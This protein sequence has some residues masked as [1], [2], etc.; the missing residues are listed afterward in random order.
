MTVDYGPAEYRNPVHPD[1]LSQMVKTKPVEMLLPFIIDG[2]GNYSEKKK[3][4]HYFNDF[5]SKRVALILLR[6]RKR[7]HCDIHSDWR[8]LFFF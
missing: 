4:V 6:L 5:S 8:M 7:E 1:R 3:N 2:N